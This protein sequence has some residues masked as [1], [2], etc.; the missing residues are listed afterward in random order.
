MVK[1]F[2]VGNHRG[3]QHKSKVLVLVSIEAV[4]P[5]PLKKFSEH[6]KTPSVQNRTD[7]IMQ[8]S[9]IRILF[10]NDLLQQEKKE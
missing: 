7:V 1:L 9:M 4:L 2:I 5:Y 3:W 8:V 6:L 10:G